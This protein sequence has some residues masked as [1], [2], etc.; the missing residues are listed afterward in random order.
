MSSLSLPLF[1]ASWLRL[2]SGCCIIYA[3]KNIIAIFSHLDFSYRH[4]W[5]L[6]SNP[7]LPL[8][9]ST[10]TS[11]QMSGVKCLLMRSRVRPQGGQKGGGVFGLR[12]RR[13]CCVIG[14]ICSVPRG[15]RVCVC[16]AWVVSVVCGFVVSVGKSRA[17]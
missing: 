9:P 8:P 10:V 6:P 15:E 14:P 16:V 4:A 12:K 5:Y 13:M 2:C 1:Y 17:D 3:H 11:C 7:P